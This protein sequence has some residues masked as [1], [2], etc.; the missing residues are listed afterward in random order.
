MTVVDY[1]VYVVT[2]A[3]ERYSHGLL[4]N[5]EAA[6]AGGASMIQYRSTSTAKGALYETA[7]A[8]HQLLKPRHVPLIINDHVDLALAVNAE[9]V[10]VG[11]KDLP[12]AVVRR[13]VGRNCIVGLSVTQPS[14][15]STV[16]A[17]LVD[18][19]GIGPVYPTLSKSDAAPALGLE[20][21]RRM[22]ALSPV[23]VVAIGG[24]SLERAA[25]VFG[26]GVAGVAVVAAISAANDPA[27]AAREL[28]DAKSR[29]ITR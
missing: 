9:G 2:D 29:S 23:P 20:E 17:T 7:R 3:P 25:A 14:E 16:D 6:I 10:H 4:T 8:L 12:V 15:L 13:L 18:Y 1:S 21:L 11:Q 24:I 26:T 28:R 5:I 19:L 22:V 27:A